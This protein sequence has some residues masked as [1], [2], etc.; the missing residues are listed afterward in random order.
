M[1][2]LHLNSG[3]ET[4]GGMIHILS[5]LNQLNRDEFTLGLLEE[6]MMLEKAKQLGI[7]TVLFPQ[8]SKIDFSVFKQICEY[9]K[10]NRI[11]MIHTH[12]PRANF[13]GK[14]LK[15]KTGCKW[16]LTLHSD[17]HDD[18]LG[19]GLK[20]RLL[21]YLNISTI[22]KADHLFA[23][24]ERFKD[25]LVKM[26]IH[27]RKITTI[28]NGID[29]ALEVTNPYKREDFHFQK[30]DFLIIMVAR[31]EKVKGHEIA[32]KA[33]KSVVQQHPHAHLLLIG[34]GTLKN[35]LESVV[36]KEKLTK[37]VHFFGYRDRE[38]VEKFFPLA[39]VAIL[40]SFSES[41]PLVLLEAARAGVPVITSDVGGVRELVPNEQ[42]GWVTEIGNSEQLRNAI[43]DAIRLKE[44]GELAKKGER[45]RQHAAL[46]FSVENFAKSVY[47]T[48]L[49]LL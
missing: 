3:N 48:Y 41:F 44:E 12:G 39:D 17:P 8:K 28:F 26:N 36:K 5:L 15:E 13:F 34:D 33:L 1:Q 37:H 7:R 25:I 9:I 6:G 11:D 18:F 21:T 47:D 46:R 35:H 40:T 27:E 32:L 22:K 19:K 10:E 14:F 20:G 42:Y 2:I 24:S 29:F 43:L 23:I 38:D 31:L 45:L 30:N 49:K 4:G 16:V